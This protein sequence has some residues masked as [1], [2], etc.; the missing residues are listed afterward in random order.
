MVYELELHASQLSSR[1]HGCRVRRAG[2]VFSSS[3]VLTSIKIL[4]ITRD[5]EDVT[6][7]T[8]DA[9]AEKFKEELPPDVIVATRN[10][11]KLDDRVVAAVEEALIGHGGES[12][13]DTPV[14]QGEE[15][16]QQ[17]SA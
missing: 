2:H 15:G 12:A 8:L 14:A 11:F 10:F 17:A 7:A 16:M 1:R 4:G 6:T 13:L 3:S 5:G 9:F